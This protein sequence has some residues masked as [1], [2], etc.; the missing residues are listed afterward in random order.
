MF[1]RKHIEK[2]HLSCACNVHAHNISC[3]L[4]CMGGA[5]EGHVECMSGAYRVH[6]RCMP[7]ACEVHVRVQEKTCTSTCT[8]K[9]DMQI[10]M[11]LV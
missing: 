4:W 3:W 6:A 1:Q 9:R 2:V 7:G 11:H 5:C 10:Y 8:D